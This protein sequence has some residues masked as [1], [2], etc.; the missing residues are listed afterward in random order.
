MFLVCITMVKSIYRG[1]TNVMHATG[2]QGN[3]HKVNP[4]KVKLKRCP[5]RNSQYFKVFYWV[6][7]GKGKFSGSGGW[8]FKGTRHMPEEKR[9]VIILEV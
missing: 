8:D 6:R 7:N 3:R 9:N 2:Q 4:F 1:E 5:G